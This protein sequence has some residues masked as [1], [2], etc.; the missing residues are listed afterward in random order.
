MNIYVILEWDGG[1]QYV[2]GKAFINEALA[3]KYCEGTESRLDYTE[4]TLDVTID[5]RR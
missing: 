4:A 3:K 2:E 1:K 5:P